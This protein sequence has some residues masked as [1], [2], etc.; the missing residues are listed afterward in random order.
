MALFKAYAGCKWK[1]SDH[2]NVTDDV[3]M[4]WVSS[5]KYL[6]IVLVAGAS[7]QIDCAYVKRKFYASR[8]AAGSKC[9]YAE[10]CVGLS[11]VRSMCLPLLTYCLGAL[12]LPQYGF[13]ELGVC[14]I[15]KFHEMFLPFQYYC[16]DFTFSDIYSRCRTI[17]RFFMKLFKTNNYKCQQFF[18]FELPSV[19]AEKGPLNSKQCFTLTIEI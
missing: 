15:Y 17:D 8:N 16:G 3:P 11:L 4:P 12:D 13:P 19:T 7:L 5:I 9:K 18:N 14:W 6:G 2:T 10:E 1:C